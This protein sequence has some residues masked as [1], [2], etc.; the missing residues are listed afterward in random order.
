MRYK[1]ILPLITIISGFFLLWSCTDNISGPDDKINVPKELTTAEKKL[2]ETGHSFSFD[3]FK[4]TVAYDGEKNI[5]ISPL[6]ISIALGMTMNGARG[7]TF[8]QMRETLAFQEIEMEEINEGYQLLIERLKEA[9][10]KVDMEIANSVWSREGFQVEEEFIND[11][12]TYF[13]AVADELDFNDPKSAEI[14]NQWV[15]DNTNGLIEKIIS[16][17]I[18]PNV[19]MYL[20]NAIYFKGDWTHPFE[21]EKTR[22]ASFFLEN[23]GEVTVDMMNQDKKFNAYFSDEVHMLDLPYGDSLYSMTLVM[24]ADEN[25]SVNEFIENDLTYDNFNSWI[26]QL[27]YS[28]T[29]VN[30]PKFEMEYEITLNDV[31]KSMGMEEP[32]NTSADFTG[33]HAKGGLWIGEVKHKTF[34]TVDEKGTEAAAV[35]SVSMVDSA[36][37]SFYAN[38]PFVFVIREQSTGAIIFMGKMINPN[39]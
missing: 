13:N 18:P 22:E 33:I 3:I 24:P 38:R 34:V 14:I 21:E 39:A 4:H 27:S 8:D 31:L 29:I 35:T 37:P 11:L 16:G 20:I 5:F 25:I 1:R 30:L 6:S 26:D 2:V 10:S 28:R 32:F 15:E 19:L 36:P 12:E 7:E 23:G 9:D 17:N